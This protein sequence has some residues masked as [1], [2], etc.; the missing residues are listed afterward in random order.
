MKTGASDNQL[1]HPSVLL[2]AIKKKLIPHNLW[3]PMILVTY[4][5]RHVGNFRKAYF[6]GNHYILLKYQQEPFAPTENM[7]NET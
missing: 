1:K 3:V 7:T 5:R 2:A 6:V 4:I